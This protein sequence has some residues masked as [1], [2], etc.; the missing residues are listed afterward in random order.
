MAS[1]LAAK[2]RLFAFQGAGDVAVL[3]ADDPA[4]AATV[5]AARKAVLSRS[6]G[7]W[8]G[9]SR[10]IVLMLDGEPLVQT[11]EVRLSRAHNLANALAAA[12][13][14]ARRSARTTERWLRCLRRFEG[15]E[16]RHR[17]V[18]SDGGV[19]WVDDSKA[20]NVGATAGGLRGYP[21]GS[22][23]LILGGQGKGQDSRLLERRDPAG[24][25]ARLPDRGGRAGHR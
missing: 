5:T 25:G 9:V 22:V 10:T 19:A 4:V 3:N 11:D 15:L 23:H 24:G 2:R 6:R 1:Y 7:R 20:T 8:T 12:S 14:A 21:D 16:H 17:M 18:H 13:L